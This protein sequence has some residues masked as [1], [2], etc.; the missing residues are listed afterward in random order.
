[1]RMPRALARR[2][3]SVERPAL[4]C[5]TCTCPPVSSASSASR[6]T[7]TDSAAS[8]IPFIPSRVEVQPSCMTPSPL[9]SGSSACWM[10]GIPRGRVSSSARRM[11]SAFRTGFPSSEIATA[12]ASTSSS[13]SVSDSPICPRVTAAIGWTRAC[14]LS[15]ARRIT[16]SILGL[17]SSGGVV[18]GMQATVVNP[19]RAAARVPDSIVSFSSCPGSRRCTWMSTSPGQITAPFTDSTSAARSDRTSAGASSPRP[20]IFPS[21]IQRSWTR[22]MPRAGSRTLPPRMQR[23]L[24]M[25]L[26]RL[27]HRMLHRRL[28][29]RLVSREEVENRHPHGH[30]VRDL[31]QDDRVLSVRHV[32]GDLNPAVH[33]AGMHD[34]DVGLRPFEARARDAVDAC[35]LAERRVE[36][37]A[38]ALELDS[39]D[40]HHVRALDCLVHALRDLHAEALHLHGHHGRGAGDG[41]AGAELSEPPDV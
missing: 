40:V 9:R 23:G 13:I 34:R 1:M 5:A 24:A 4:T 2:M 12:P 3:I 35:V 32:L 11:I 41:D 19:P 22:S 39:Q 26:L 21:T 17:S 30:P 36:C 16:Y 18:F 37:A 29:R 38:L 10:T 28:V 7:I 6:A 31:L 8:G 25:G 14:P 20:E 33:R 15:R 27:L